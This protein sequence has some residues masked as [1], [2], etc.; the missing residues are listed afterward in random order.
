MTTIQFEAARRRF[1]PV[2]QQEQRGGL[3]IAGRV[4]STLREWRRRARDRAEL[5]KLDHRMLRDIGLTQADA[6]FLSSKPFWRE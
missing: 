2:P 3:G 6:E 1:S 5:S 4:L